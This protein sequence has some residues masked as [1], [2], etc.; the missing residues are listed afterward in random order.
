MSSERRRFAACARG[1]SSSHSDPLLTD[2]VSNFSRS[3]T[4]KGFGGREL[5]GIDSVKA[6][7]NMID[8]NLNRPSIWARLRAPTHGW[9]QT[10]CRG[11]ELQ[12]RMDTD[13]QEEIEQ[14]ARR[15]VQ[16]I[17]RGKESKRWGQKDGSS[18]Q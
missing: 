7:S 15:K 2:K 5:Q 10:Q 18:D 12:P 14:T 16:D 11:R 4:R 3:G 13:L 17:K 6:T 8:I 9:L 1:A